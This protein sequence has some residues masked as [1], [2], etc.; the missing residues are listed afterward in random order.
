MAQIQ[1]K[2][3]KSG[4]NL[5]IGG[6]NIGLNGQNDGPQARIGVFRL[7]LGHFAWIWAIMLGFG[8]FGRIW[9]Q[10]GPK[11]D[12]ALRM[13]QGGRNGWTDGRTDS[14]CVPQDFVAFGSAAQKVNNSE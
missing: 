11:R 13:G 9:V 2:W 10:I 6:H 4:Q 7:D 1:A 12:E 8:L 5:D 14:P 3:S